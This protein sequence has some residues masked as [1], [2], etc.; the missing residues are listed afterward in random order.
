MPEKPA[1][2]ATVEKKKARSNYGDADIRH[3]GAIEGVRKNLGMYIG[4]AAVTGMHHLVN[5]IVDNSVDEFVG[6]Y[7]DKITVTIHEDQ[8]LSVKDR[9]RGIPVGMNEKA[10][11]PTLQLVFTEL[12][13]GGKFENDQGTSAYIAS[14]GLHGV[15][16]TVVNASSTWLEAESR[17]EGGAWRIRFED[18]AVV[19][20]VERVGDSDETGTTVR[21]LPDLKI[22]GEK[23][24]ENKLIQDHIEFSFKRLAGRMR[25]LAFLNAGLTIEV[26]DE[27]PEDEPLVETFHSDTGL[28]GY[29]NLLV[30]TAG[31]GDDDDDDEDGGEDGGEGGEGEGEPGTDDKPKKKKSR[32]KELTQRT[33]VIRLQGELEHLIIDIALQ[34]TDADRE[35]V[36]AYCNNIHNS[37]G[38]KHVEGLRIAIAH[39]LEKKSKEL[40]ELD[41]KQP[42]KKIK[43]GADKKAS[44]AVEPRGDDYRYGLTAVISVKHPRPTF[45]NQNKTKLVSNEVAGI[46]QR[47]VNDK[48]ASFLEENPDVTKTVRAVAEQAAKIRDA[49]KKARESI[50]KGQNLGP[51]KLVPCRSKDNTKTELFLV[52][53]D[54]AA[55]PAKQARDSMFQ[56]VLSLR[57]KILNVEK[58]KVHKML[59]HREIVELIRAIGCGITT[60]AGGEEFNLDNRKY[61]KII[62]MTDADVDGAHI[63]TLLLTFFFRQMAPL[64]EHGHMYVV[65]P[66]LYAFKLSGSKKEKPK[67]IYS[68]TERDQVLLDLGLSHGGVFKR[69]AKADDDVPSEALKPEMRDE[70]AAKDVKELI[71]QVQKLEE[72]ERES[73]RKL[74]NVTLH[75]FLA[76]LLGTDDAADGADDGADD[77]KASKKKGKGKGKKDDDAAKPVKVTLRR[78]SADTADDVLARYYIRLGAV[79]HLFRTME[80]AEKFAESLAGDSAPAKP[81]ADAD[82]DAAAPVARRTV[83]IAEI[84]PKMRTRVVE[85]LQKIEAY[86]SKHNIGIEH[87][88]VPDSGGAHQAPFIVTGKNAAWAAGSLID[89]VRLL[90]RAGRTSLNEVT[91]FKG[92]GEM[93]KDELAETAIEIGMR[94][95]LKI[96]VD[97]ALEA[98]E[99]FSTLMGTD[100][101]KRYEFI[102]TKAPTATLDV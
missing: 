17:R 64:I 97:D 87:L 25:E 43:A 5:E 37:E 81:A 78:I 60:A 41:G 77:G 49:M 35:R 68:S 96:T 46:V 40:A 48:L 10:G 47:F 28:E 76:P 8:S 99:L 56:A 55:G 73:L 18:G 79:T 102:S 101:T 90:R 53:G 44:K 89:V 15:G 42:T 13:A 11:V 86:G 66:P 62:I 12:H 63:R 34:W 30:G 22:F 26:I 45:S 69:G 23:D 27:R 4:D 59:G 19:S 36:E 92:L 70:I 6:G 20:K 83:N 75:E 98:E 80:D 85:S 72:L 65:L 57:G 95:L 67:Y 16:A 29:L 24:D 1:A 74:Y 91:R 82:P 61:G 33:P 31:E 38:G 93:N 84:G 88:L 2:T 50:K 52:E 100:V 58:A 21:F 32:K 39:T 3:L 7:G 94:R 71:G 54:S 14:G 9:G 51:S